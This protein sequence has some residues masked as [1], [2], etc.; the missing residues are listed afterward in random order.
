MIT[1][2]IGIDLE[3]NTYGAWYPKG[4]NESTYKIKDETITVAYSAFKI[5]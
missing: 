4:I 2:V 3:K 1:S 5:E